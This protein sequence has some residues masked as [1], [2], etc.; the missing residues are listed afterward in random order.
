MV[1]ARAVGGAEVEC[2]FG[3]G[4]GRPSVNISKRYYIAIVIEKN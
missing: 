4:A 3:M 2:V 1:E